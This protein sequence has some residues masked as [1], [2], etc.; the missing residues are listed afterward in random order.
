MIFLT[1]SELILG[2]AEYEEK[3]LDD[4]EIIGADCSF[5]IP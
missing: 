5:G 2:L 4:K 3:N 1:I